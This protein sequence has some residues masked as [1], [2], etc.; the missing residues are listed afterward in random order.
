[1]AV[2]QCISFTEAPYTLKKFTLKM[3]VPGGIPA[4]CQGCCPQT[5]MMF[6]AG[7][8]EDPSMTVLG[9]QGMVAIDMV[10]I[11]REDNLVVRTSQKDF[12]CSLQLQAWL[13]VV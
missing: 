4:P 8:L 11:G 12:S 3:Q 5:S 13:K 2:R 9:C 6:T 10:A 7:L 1:M